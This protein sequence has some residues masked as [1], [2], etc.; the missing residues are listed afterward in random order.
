MPYR[1]FMLSWIVWEHDS[2]M[3]P[4]KFDCLSYSDQIQLIVCIRVLLILK[5]I[6]LTESECCFLLKKFLG[7]VPLKSN[8]IMFVSFPIG[9][10]FLGKISG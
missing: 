2:V 4:Q 7:N 5:K 1:G 8:P 6:F 10:K 3:F 9:K